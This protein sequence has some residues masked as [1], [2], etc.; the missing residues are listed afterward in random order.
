MSVIFKLYT[1]KIA[2]LIF[3]K[4]TPISLTNDN[5]NFQVVSLSADSHH[6]FHLFS[7]IQ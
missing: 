6:K 2:L 3:W 5:F 1:F 4:N 7:Y